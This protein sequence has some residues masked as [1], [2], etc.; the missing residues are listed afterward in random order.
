MSKITKNVDFDIFSF[1]MV[2][3]DPQSLPKR[4]KIQIVKGLFGFEIL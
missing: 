4:V 3:F 2:N 1:E